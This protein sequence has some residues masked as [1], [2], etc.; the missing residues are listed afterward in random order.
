MICNIFPQ[1][2]LLD[3]VGYLF[4]Q[5]KAILGGMFMVSVELTVLV[6]VSLSW[7]SFDFS[8]P[9]NEFLVLNFYEYLGDGSVEWGKCQF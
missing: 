3:K 2:P 7:I 1:I 4:L 9:L 5:L 6:S 8:K